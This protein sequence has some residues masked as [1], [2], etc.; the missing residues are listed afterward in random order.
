MGANY[1]GSRVYDIV[2]IDLDMPVKTGLGDQ[3]R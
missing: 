2:F 3:T 1:L